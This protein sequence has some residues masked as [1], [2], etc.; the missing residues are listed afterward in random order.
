MRITLIPNLTREA[1][2]RVTHRVCA[3]LDSLGADYSFFEENKAP[4]DST[5]ASFLPPD[6]ALAGCD[7][8]IAVGG[9][10]SIIH[11]AKYAVMHGKPILGIN[12]G[13]LAYMAGLED[14]ELDLLPR[15]IDGDY[16]LDRRIMLK[17]SVMD[18]DKCL[19]SDFCVNDCFITNE[20]KQRMSLID[21]ASNG[22][23]FN[24]YLCDG[25]VVATPTGST[26]R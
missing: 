4:F 25:I 20:E 7:A 24:S 6:E 12:A 8:V 11:A 17:A 10:G 19:S 21:V 13:R 22:R 14:D 26:A 16:T 9:D 2:L 1:A 15:L 18:G 23:V 5:K 3:S